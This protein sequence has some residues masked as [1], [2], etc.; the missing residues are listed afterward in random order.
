MDAR[1]A[2]FSASLL[3]AAWAP[4]AAIAQQASGRGPGTLD[5]GPDSVEATGRI[6]GTIVDGVTGEPVGVAQVRLRE[7]R[8]SELSHAN[9]RFHFLEIRPGRYT[10]S[11]ERLGYAPAERQVTVEA[12]RTVDV[13]IEL[14]P[15]A[16][17]I[18][19]VVV[20]GTGRE[21]GAGE[22]YQPTSV[23]G[24]AELRRRLATSL[25]AT[26]AHEPGIHQQYNGPA[27]SQPV[28]RGMGGDRVVMLEDGH[29][30]GDLYS[31][32]SDHAVTVEP[33]TVERIEVLRGPAALLY[34]S[35]ALGGVVNVIREDVPRSLPERL[36]GTASLQLESVNRGAS[37]GVAGW[38]PMGRLSVRG[39]ASGRHA[40]DTRTPLGV[41]ESTG[42]EGYTLGAGASLIT[43]WG[44]VGAAA[45]EARMDYGVPGEFGGVVIPGAH[46]GGVDI[47]TTRRTARIEA[48]H[49]GGLGVFNALDLSASLNHYL[50][51]EI[52]GRGEA[53][54]R[55]LGARFDQISGGVELT[56]RH[57]HRPDFPLLRGGALGVEYRGKDLRARGSSPGTRSATEN[58][59]AIF[60]YEELALEPFRFK[61]GFRY[62]HAR[63]DPYHDDPIVVGDRAI[64]V[65]SRSFGSFSGSVAALFDVTQ[66]WTTGVSVARAFR[67]PAI[68]ELFSD[69]PHLADFSFDIGNPELDPEFGL[70]V[71]L[72]V[73]GTF[74][75]L[76]LEAS[77]F[78]NRLTNY[79][80]YQATG[81]LDPRF[82]RYPVFEARGDDA[83]FVGLEGRAQW[84]AARNLVID[85]SVSG[86]RAT[87]TETDDPLPD[88][89]PVT[90]NA[91]IRYDAA[92]WFGSLGVDAMAAQD[93]VPQAFPSPVDGALVQ[94]QRPTAGSALLNAGFGWRWSHGE[95]FHTVTLQVSNL[96]DTEWRDHLSR[97]KDVAPQPGRNIQI[98]YRLNY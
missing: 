32:G 17:E 36:A 56:L 47:E 10:L 23:I 7:M 25:A 2:M 5:P 84:E 6:V 74:P 57:E 54:E 42:I 41:L 63:I 13:T 83:L 30:T 76:H 28:I 86:V 97:I 37:A 34:G 51:D 16:L 29:R 8:R 27:A 4:G 82:R 87:R 89:P 72:F 40:G 20:T 92:R 1:T 9:G 66:D 3:L 38:L 69:G 64:P 50:H 18:P 65:R 61:A 62:D 85:G 58:G 73:R 88:I 78:A 98:L 71:D 35:S 26:I 12:E 52:E 15:S 95:R 93:R 43:S 70:G 39:E 90:V 49:L 45:R 48:A 55:Y 19:G 80:H 91:R 67:R 59:F 46:P 79:I 81:E 94:P 31:T 14:R 24:D 77:A 21:R 33:L 60:L 11:V 75:R 68:E 96:L 53:G 44:F 22:V